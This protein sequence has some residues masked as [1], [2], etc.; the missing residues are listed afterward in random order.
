MIEFLERLAII[1]VVFFVTFG[2]V[3]AN[4]LTDQKRVHL[5]LWIVFS[6]SILGVVGGT[7]LFW[8]LSRMD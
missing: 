1:S 3:I 7:L 6:L 2:I 4:L 5:F 8:S